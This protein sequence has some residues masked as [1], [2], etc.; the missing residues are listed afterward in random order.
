MIGIHRAS[1][2][3]NKLLYVITYK[4]N[5]VSVAYLFQILDP[6]C[7]SWDMSTVC[8]SK[9]R[10]KATY[11]SVTLYLI[12]NKPSAKNIVY[13]SRSALYFLLLEYHF[14]YNVDVYVFCNH[15]GCYC[16]T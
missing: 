15:S 14:I 16:R 7:Y 3:R 8:S 9:T 11:E 5:G 12:Q 10:T 13:L 6:G 1:I 2:A 4:L